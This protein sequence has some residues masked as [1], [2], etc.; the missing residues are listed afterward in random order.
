MEFTEKQKRAVYTKGKSLLVSAAAGSGK[1]SVLTKRI[2]TLIEQGESVEDMA[3]LTF[4]NAA[5]SEMRVRISAELSKKKGSLHCEEQAEKVLGANIG[6]FHKICNKIIRDS[7]ELVGVSFNV[8]QLGDTQM[9]NMRKEAM[10]ALC[11]ECFENNI[12]QFTDMVK[13]YG[14]R[15]GYTGVC[16]CIEK[17]YDFIMSR[18]QSEKWLYDACHISKEDYCSCVSDNEGLANCISEYDFISKRLQDIYFLVLK[19]KGIYE[20][21]KRS[22][23]VIDYDDMLHMA[24]NITMQKDCRFKYVFVD[25]YQDT[26]PIQEEFVKHIS[27]PDKCFMVGD[28]KQSIYR[29]NQATP[30]NFLR[31]YDEFKKEDSQK[32]IAMNENFRCSKQVVDAVNSIMETLMTREMGGIDYDEDE[33]LIFKSGND[34]GGAKV[35][36]GGYYK[37]KEEST[38][39]EA[40]MIAAQ[41]QNILGKKAFID[42]KER[43]V[44]PG[45]IVVL[46]RSRDEDFIKSL[47]SE[48]AGRDIPLS[49]TVS[50]RE[51]TPEIEL[52]VQI[53][54]TIEDVRKDIPL[55][56]VMRSIVGGFSDEELS[57]VRKED[58]KSNFYACVTE[59]MNRVDNKLSH[60][61]EKFTDNIAYLKECSRAMDMENFIR[62]VIVRFGYMDI[63]SLR[64][65]G[66][67]DT[68]LGFI[69]SVYEICQRE[70]QSLYALINELETVKQK[71]DCYIQTKAKQS[72]DSVSIMTMHGS[73]G[74]EFPIVFVS[75]LSK[76]MVGKDYNSDKI[77]V[78][79]NDYG[80]LLIKSDEKRLIKKPSARR[81]ALVEK[82]KTEDKSEE[83]RLLYVAMTRAKCFLYLTGCYSNRKEEKTESIIKDIHEGNSQSAKCML[84]FVMSACE[85][86]SAINVEK[87]TDI[88]SAGEKTRETNKLDMLLDM[89]SQ[90]EMIC[91]KRVENVPTKLSVSEIK[92]QGETK[93]IYYSPVAQTDELTGAKLGSIVHI[94]LERNDPANEKCG[95]TAKRL[96]DSQ[97]LTADEYEAIMSNS[98]LV[99][100]FLQTDLA[101][102]IYSSE[103]VIK[104]QPFNLYVSGD[105]LGYESDE[106]IMVQGIIDLAFK[107]NGQWVIVDYKTDRVNDRNIESL[108]EMYKKQID[109]YSQALEKITG[110]KVKERILC[111]LRGNISVAV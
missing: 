72:A 3:I 74:L 73:K 4:T 106:K 35:L 81:K 13:V 5:A 1:T 97:I 19:F 66:R 71:Q 25:E 57:Q 56:A 36:F 78:V 54:K 42:G 109:L 88:K 58:K 84:D 41:M 64:R 52:F 50:E 110:I 48:C 108:K 46:V 40:Q 89:P 29:F 68:F 70:G 90:G 11:E 33:R 62:E 79:H 45:N 67:K 86:E 65:S 103:Y 39:A 77:C 37:N 17:I 101:K 16:N 21:L 85:N 23:N 104:E 76:D 30:A 102:R 69:S 38:K 63:V 96:L 9:E 18:P 24:L 22:R 53:L 31:R 111:F 8:K 44:K 2:V 80:I 60:K 82:I 34:K 87:C 20:D 59:Y 93:K 94:I 95:D 43:E 99:D 47:K 98:Q 26:N 7:F 28:I 27:Y 49:V 32:I 55:I 12:P 92:Q 75:N 100:D 10:D 107:E 91:L 15:G 61:L 14:K 6:T 105:K 83:L 51:N